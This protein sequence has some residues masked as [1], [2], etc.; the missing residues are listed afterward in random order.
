MDEQDINISRLSVWKLADYMINDKKEKYNKRNIPSPSKPQIP[1]H[2][3]SSY[4]PKAPHL[5]KIPLLQKLNKNKNT[6]TNINTDNKIPDSPVLNENS[7]PI[8]SNRH[9]SHSSNPQQGIINLTDSDDEDMTESRSP[10]KGR[11]KSANPSKKRSRSRSRSKKNT[12]N[13][14]SSNK[15][16]DRNRKNTNNSQKP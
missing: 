6:N 11:S 4:N 9:K 1:Q 8:P 10:R 12:S 7:S 2:I 13:K 5:K 14:P 3:I 16:R 15:D